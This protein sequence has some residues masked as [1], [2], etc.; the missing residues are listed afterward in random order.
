MCVVSGSLSGDSRKTFAAFD[1]VPVLIVAET[2]SSV[3][4]DV[5]RYMNLGPADLIVTEGDKVQAMTMVVA[6]LWFMFNREPIEAQQEMITILRVDGVQELS[7]EQ[8]RY[9]VFPP[10]SL[11]RARALVPGFNPAKT[12]EQERERR[13]KQ[14]KKDGL[15]KADDKKE[16]SAGM[17]LLVVNNAT[18]DVVSTRGAAQQSFV[19]YLTPESFAMGEFKYDIVLDSL[20]SGT[21]ALNAT[22][23]PFLATVKAQVFVAATNLP[24]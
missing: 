3:I 2:R 21:F 8:W 7:D 4:L 20:K 24:H 11:E 17:V 16:E 14:E 9:G 23:I 18:P 1:S 22:A 13:E 19:F 6:D 10:A 12:I 15:K 5:P